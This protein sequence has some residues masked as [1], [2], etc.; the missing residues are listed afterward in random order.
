VGGQPDG[1]GFQLLH[2]FA[3][4]HHDLLVGEMGKRLHQQRQHNLVQVRAAGQDLLTAR[5]QL[6]LGPDRQREQVEQGI[7]IGGSGGSH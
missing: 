2:R 3:S 6:T 7:Q 5:R 4:N 1:Q